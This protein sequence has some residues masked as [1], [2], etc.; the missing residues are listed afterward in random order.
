MDTAIQAQRIGKGC[1]VEGCDRKHNSGGYCDTHVRRLR[2]GVE[3]TKPFNPRQGP[4]RLCDIEGCSR[5]HQANGLCRPHHARNKA[6]VRLDKP[7]KQRLAP[8]GTR[9]INATKSGGGYVQ[10]KVADKYGGHGANWKPEHHYV[11]EQHIGR[12]LVKPE[13]VHHINGIRDDNRIENLELW[14]KSQ[15]AGQRVVDKIRWAKALLKQYES[16]SQ[17]EMF[18]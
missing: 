17:F 15:P 3:L 9:R 18:N 8:V 1:S 7:I 13:N 11:M 2:R 5:P 16:V 14:S 6:V 12:S 4:N 10:I